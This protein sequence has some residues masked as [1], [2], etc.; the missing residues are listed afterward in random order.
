MMS[1]LWGRP[2]VPGLM[3]NIEVPSIEPT[4]DGWVGFATNS[5]QQYSDFLVMIGRPDLLEQKDLANARGRSKRMQEWNEIVHAWT[6]THST[7]QII[8][9]AAAL[10]IPV[11]PVNNGKTV[12]D[13]EQLLARNVF[14]E[15]PPAKPSQK[16]FMQPRTP[17]LIDGEIPF[18]LQPAPLLGADRDITATHNPYRSLDIHGISPSKTKSSQLPLAGIRILDATAWWAGPSATQMLAHLGAEVIH[19]EAIQRPDGSRMMGGAHAHQPR[20][21]EYSAM[22]LSANT[23]KQGLTLNLDDPKG[24][25]LAKQLIRHCDV[26]VE[27]YSPRVMDKFGLDWPAVHGLNSRTIMVRMPAFGLDGPWRNHVGFAQ[28]MEQISGMAWITGHAD[29]QPRIQ[30]GPCDPMAGM[31]AAFAILVALCEREHT[32]QG[33]LIECSMVEGALN[34]AAEQI[35]EYS[36]YGNI[37]ERMGNRSPDAAPQGLYQCANHDHKN[38]QWLAL[39]IETDQQWQSLKQLLGNARWTQSPELNSLAGRHKYHD[40]VDDELRKYFADKSLACILTLWRAAKVPVA[41]VASSV[42]TYSHPQLQARHFFEEITHPVVGKHLH[43]TLPFRFGSMVQTNQRWLRSPAP[44]VGE[45]NH[46]ILSSILQLSTADIEQL[47]RAGVIGNE[48]AGL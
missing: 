18:S 36:A 42:K 34:A 31:N 3:R 10:R 8:D 5:F 22:F 35:V 30:R 13:H 29:D 27:N 23:N 48:L 37:M 38:E 24:V 4:Q 17:Y 20:W 15:N 9:M 12:F 6:K 26:F 47:Q 40:L 21:Y 25:D 28:T 11:A 19:L 2:D 43:V 7:A 1:S 33:C 14:V 41:P 46:T 44:L 39:S 32:Q 45:H 16:P